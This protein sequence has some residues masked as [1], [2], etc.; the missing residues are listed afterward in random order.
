M[1][2]TYKQKYKIMDLNQLL[3]LKMREFN[4]F[5]GFFKFF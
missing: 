3:L 4:L 2:G 5:N 1:I